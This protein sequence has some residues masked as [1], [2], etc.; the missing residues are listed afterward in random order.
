M[1]ERDAMRLFWKI[2]IPALCVAVI[3]GATVLW[4][5]HNKA[6]ANERKLAEVAQACRVRA[7]QGDAEAEYDL[8][9]MYYYGQG[10]PRDY[11][12]AVRWGRKAA[13]QGYAKAEYGLGYMYYHGQG[14]PQDYGEA[15]RWWRKAADQGNAYAQ[16]ELGYIYSHGQGVPQNYAEAFGWLRK[17]ADQ[18]DA[19]S[20][21]GLGFMYYYGYG[22]QKDNAEAA[23]WYRKAADQGYAKAESGMGFMYYYGY[24]VPRN[25]AEADRWFRK[26][27][28][29][30]DEY[31]LRALSLSLT[32][33]RKSSLV[34]QF[35]AGIFLATGFLSL[36]IFEPRKS[37]RDFRQR[38][39]G[40]TG[41]L[42]LFTAGLSWYGYTHYKIRCLNCG[43]NAF[44][45]TK[46]LLDGVVIVLAI[47]ILRSAK[48]SKVQERE[49]VA[50][51]TDVKSGNDTEQ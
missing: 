45:L 7:E 3:G 6:K 41:V 19:T 42:C 40:G 35:I 29:Q 18:G 39:I 30:D 12:E 44:T 37:F 4:S 31:A 36:N 10:V 33:C 20:E 14:V 8:S 2:A 49:I 25:Y 13:D 11:A 16:R 21:N 50:E 22:V 34:I 5:V 32:T 47:Y 38:V 17:A 51:D 26:A 28:D 1:S 46:W 43:V 9:H 48:K 15:F 24:G 27:A 23:R